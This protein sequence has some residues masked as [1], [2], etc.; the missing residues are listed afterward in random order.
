MV[1]V[2]FRFRVM[3][4][5]TAVCPQLKRQ[6]LAFF[7]QLADPPIRVRVRVNSGILPPAR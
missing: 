4:L 7:L 3:S 2:R 6:R 5:V 1:G